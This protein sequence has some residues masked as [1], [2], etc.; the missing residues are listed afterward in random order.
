MESSS[1]GLQPWLW[2]TAARI[3]RLTAPVLR[4]SAWRLKSLF[5]VLAFCLV[6]AF[7]NYSYLREP[8]V[9]QSWTDAAIKSRDLGADMARL[10]PRDS[11]EAKLTYRL[12][13]PIIA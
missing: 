4:G 5:L 2:A 7:P 9:R 6:R 10:F 13:V 1:S 3:E 8:S 11:H 12:T